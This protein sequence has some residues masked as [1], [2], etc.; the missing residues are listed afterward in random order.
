MQREVWRDIPGYEHYQASNF[1]RVKRLA[2]LNKRGTRLK[3][4]ILVVSVQKYDK[5][6]H[7]RSF[8]SIGLG[9]NSVCECLSVGRA[10]LLAFEGLP[11]RPSMVCRHLDDNIRNNWW[12]NLEW[13]TQKQN[14]RD[15]IRNNKRSTYG[16]NVKTSKLSSDQVVEIRSSFRSYCR[17]NGGRA[18]AKKYGVSEG[19]IIDVAKKK[20]WQH[21]E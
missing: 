4:K 2:C 16:E 8:V 15:A 1:G 9:R 20:S 12:S 6:G 11:S 19:T 14:V 18:L 17:V 10:V 3:E 5:A 21:V 7:L 13:G